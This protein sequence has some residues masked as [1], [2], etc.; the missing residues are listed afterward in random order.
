MKIQNMSLSMGKCQKKIGAPDLPYQNIGTPAA[1][2]IKDIIYVK[3]YSI[4]S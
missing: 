3:Y 1:G 4:C 2:C